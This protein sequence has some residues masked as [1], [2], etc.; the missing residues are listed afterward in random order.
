[1]GGHTSGVTS[2]KFSPGGEFFLTASTD[3]TAKLWNLADCSCCLV[4]NGHHGAIVVAAFSLSSRFIVTASKDSTARVWRF[5]D[6]EILLRP[7]DSLARVWKLGEGE[8][9]S[10]LRGHRGAL[11]SA[12]FSPC[13]VFV[14]TASVDFRARLWRAS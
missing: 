10:H 9:I 7:K 1:M 8:C 2:A 3:S 12:A 14:A 5:A 11:T 13:A 4:L 6:R